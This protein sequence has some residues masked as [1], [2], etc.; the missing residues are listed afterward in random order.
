MDTNVNINKNIMDNAKS[1]AKNLVQ[2]KSTIRNT[3]EEER[4]QKTDKAE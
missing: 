3:E 4:Q 1:K 2:K